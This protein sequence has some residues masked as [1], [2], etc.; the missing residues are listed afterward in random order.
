MLTG[1]KERLAK[2]KRIIE[3]GN[4][5]DIRSEENDQEFEVKYWYLT[6]DICSF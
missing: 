4:E 1:W 6:L 2:G 3:R 5:A